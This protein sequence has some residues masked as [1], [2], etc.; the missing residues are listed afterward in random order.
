M[1]SDV[2]PWEIKLLNEEIDRF[3]L[4][5]LDID[6]G[7]KSKICP[8]P[9]DD[10]NTKDC[11]KCIQLFSD[12]KDSEPLLRLNC[13]CSVFSPKAIT[14]RIEKLLQYNELMRKQK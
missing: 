4:I 3:E 12:I 6:E 9:M 14:E 13:P 5:L 8:F 7:G 11:C 10:C 1:E 2:K